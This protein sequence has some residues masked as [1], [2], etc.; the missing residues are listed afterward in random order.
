MGSM[1]QY[2][3]TPDEVLATAKYQI[4]NDEILRGENIQ[5]EFIEDGIVLDGLV[6]SD[7]KKLRA[8]EIVSEILGVL[9]VTNNISVLI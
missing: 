1:D 3:L 8:E 9:N 2:G 7:E 6:D 4:E 5:V